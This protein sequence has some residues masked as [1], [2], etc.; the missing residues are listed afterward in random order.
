MKYLRVLKNKNQISSETVKQAYYPEH[1]S[2]FSMQMVFSG[3]S[4]YD[5]G[6]RHLNLY[7]DCFLALN[8]GTQYSSKVDS[9]I[10]VNM[11]S[12][13]F[14]PEFLS[15]FYRTQHKNIN[16]LLDDPFNSTE[17][18]EGFFLE[19]IYPFS[20]DMKYNILNLKNQ[21]ELESPDDLLINEYLHH[22]LINYFKIY[23]K[24]VSNKS[25][26]LSFLNKSTKI[27]ILKRLTFAKEYISSNYNKNIALDDIAQTACLS[28]NHLLR[29]FKQAYGISPHQYLIKVRINRSKYLL[30][31]TKYTLNEIVEIVGF[32]CPSSFI[33]LFKTMNGITPGKYRLNLQAS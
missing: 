1:I 25:E 32:E 18:S 10:P 12:I 9:N 2:N 15:D 16:A 29:T 31:N 14:A 7:P 23:N 19:T 30:I 8:K 6:K 5:I 4:T 33:R 3:N 26:N 28:V 21:L 27:E 17:H 11:L 22:S 20:G 13:S 24:E